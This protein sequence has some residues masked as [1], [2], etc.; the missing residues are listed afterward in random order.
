MYRFR[1]A[2]INAE[3]FS[4]MEKLIKHDELVHGTYC[5]NAKFLRMDGKIKYCSFRM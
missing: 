1:P 3:G 4:R 5:I 2:E